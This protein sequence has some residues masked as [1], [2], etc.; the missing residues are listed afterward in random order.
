MAGPMPVRL[1]YVAVV[2]GVSRKTHGAAGTFDIPLTFSG[3]PAVECRSSGGN[4]T[5]VFTFNNT[6]SS[7]S[8]AVTSGVGTVSGSP[9]ISGNTMTVNLTGVADVQRVTVTLQSVTDS[10]AQVMPDTPVN[11][12]MLIADTNGNKAV[13]ASDVAQTKGQVGHTVASANF[14]Q[15]VNVSGSMTSADVALVKANN[16]HGVP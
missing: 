9:V 3:E 6:L 11:I 13:N 15:D 8:A 10:T 16:G 7:G 1:N 12:N 4:H 14:R 2:S 5:L